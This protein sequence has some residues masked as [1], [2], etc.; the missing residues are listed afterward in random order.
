MQA[1]VPARRQVQA[2]MRG[3]LL[4]QE[5]AAPA[6]Q[7]APRPWLYYPLLSPAALPPQGQQHDYEA[8]ALHPPVLA[9]VLLV[10]VPAPAPLRAALSL[11]LVAPQPW[12]YQPLMSPAALPQVPQHEQQAISMAPPRPFHR[13]MAALLRYQKVTQLQLGWAQRFQLPSAQQMLVLVPVSAQVLLVRLPTR[14]LLLTR[15]P[16]ALVAP[17][18]WQGQQH[19]RQATRM[20]LSRCQTVPPGRAPRLHLP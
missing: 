12:P 2:R 8:T 5:L 15:V 1:Q 3:Q 4:A 20:S 17:R 13:Q 19:G 18:P 6:A 16:A 7:T 9:R 10:R 11:A 14:V